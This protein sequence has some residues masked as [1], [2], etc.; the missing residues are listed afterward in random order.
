MKKIFY[1]ASAMLVALTSCNEILDE[2]DLMTP[3]EQTLMTKLVGDT[4]CEAE[5]GV[6]LV[7]FKESTAID[8][9]D[10]PCE[11]TLAPAL[12]IQPKN[13]EVARKYGLH[14]WFTLSFDENIPVREVAEK[15][16]TMPE[17]TSIQ[18]DSYLT[19]IVSDKVA[20]F[21][22]APQTKYTPVPVTEET[23]ND[24]HF[25]YQWK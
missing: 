16:A 3:A 8:G 20:Q 12:P 15:M 2:S 1:V 25:P 21:V 10:L 13:M 7:K 23:F 17:V 22:P 19:P 18:F 14:R 24:P 5:P 11:A 4:D 6:L 9:L